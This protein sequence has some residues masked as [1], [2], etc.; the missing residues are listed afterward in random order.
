VRFNAI[1]CRATNS[2]IGSVR[3][4]CLAAFV[5]GCVEHPDSAKAADLNEDAAKTASS[6]PNIYLDLRTIYTSVPAGALAI[7]FSNPSSVSSVIAALERLSTLSTC[8]PRLSCRRQPARAP[9]S[10]FR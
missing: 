9:G 2:Q 7:G 3:A 4:F 10:M 6:L 8:P 1:C 5:L